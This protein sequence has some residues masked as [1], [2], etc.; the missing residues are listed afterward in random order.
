MTRT[1]RGKGLA[2]L[3]GLALYPVAQAAPSFPEQ[4]KVCSYDA[5][6][7][8]MRS[9]SALNFPAPVVNSMLVNGA[10]A[11][12]AGG[13]AA[14]VIRPGDTI[15]LRG[16]GFGNGPDVDFSKVMIGNSRVLETNLRMFNQSL[17]ILNEVNY[18]TPF[19]HSTWSKD[20][21]SWS[22]SQVQFKVPVHASK[23]P[24]RL[25]V[26][27][28]VGYLD[29]LLRPGQPHNVI[30]AQTKR[31][32][33]DLFA[34]KCDVVSRLGAQTRAI[35]PINVTVSNTGFSS[36][37]AQGRKIFWSYD[38]NIG[39][40]HKMRDLDWAKIFA[41]K[42]TDPITRQPADPAKLFGAYKTVAGEVPAEAINDVYFDPYPMANPIPGF[43]LATPQKTRGNTRNTGWVG[44][45]TAESSHPYT[46]S[47]A[48]AGFNCASC[49]GYRI[50]YEKAPGTKITKVFPG[51]P[52]PEWSMKWTVLGDKAGATTA[53]FKGIVAKEA[54]PSWA[55]GEADI[56]K[57]TLLYYM[58]AGAGE[59]NI[60]RN[61]GE[62]SE[63]DNDYQ[64]SPITIPNVTNHMP[65]RRS[66]SH[67]ES[68]VG[69][70]GSYIHS[71]EPDGAMG[72]MRAAELKALTAYMTTLDADDN[73]LINAGMYRWLKSRGKLATQTGNA[74]LAEG[75]FVQAGWQ[76]YPGVAAE[77]NRG[78]LAY[79]RDCGS[80]HNDNVGANSNE[81]MFRLD[82]VGRFFAPTIYQKDQQSIRTAY[83]RDMYWTQSRGLLSD[84]HVRNLEDLVNP[85][86]CSEGSPLYNQYYTL[87]APVRPAPG[88]PDQPT[89]WPD[90][91]RKGD[92][93]RVY[94]NTEYSST[95][96]STQRNRFIERH[97]Y[98]VKVDW[99]TENYYWDY[100]KM[101][102]EYGPGELGTAQPIGLPAAPHPWCSATAGDIDSTV[103][104]VLTK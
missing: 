100:Q 20:V 59:H 73:D 66:L 4:E 57:T 71:E 11:W 8:V 64:F 52:N 40:A 15:T 98:F 77:V 90:L 83:L 19:T 99:D 44:Y 9:L 43:L 37:V 50:S 3:A 76:S 12:T 41:Y 80:C 91:N 68:Y 55:P 39:L 31:I 22:D 69:F 47:G 61:V 101:R 25:Q 87:H 18:E 35:T 1:S 26:Q 74:A 36:L 79:D 32:S 94:R 17:D 6:R 97:K 103:Q 48:W 7:E 104:Y 85:E 5:G 56:D 30:D 28:R 72:S 23:G 45:R 86:R 88:S 58:P 46:G 51:L 34:H 82:Q 96:P 89:P 84:G 2:L 60:V 63:T 21:L 65:I 14:P 93:F 67:T 92:V 49:H 10:L 81:R 27:K 16:S 29:S 24:I 95:D 70:E 33:T 75:Q 102:R 54:G 42:T 53:T 62:G 78:K 38:F 13:T